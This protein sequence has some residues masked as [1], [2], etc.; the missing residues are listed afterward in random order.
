MFANCPRY[1]PIPASFNYF[2]CTTMASQDI[3]SISAALSLDPAIHHF[4]AA[5]GPPTL[6]L[7]ITSHYPDPITIYADDLSPKLMTNCGGFIITDLADGVEVQQAVRR[8]CR[9]PLPN[10][11]TVPI[12]EP[13]FHTLL[14][15]TPLTL[16]APFS[17]PRTNNRPLPRSDPEY[18]T[19]RNRVCGV[20]GL[21]SGHKYTLSLSG[22]PNI[23]WH[24][25]RWWEY[26]TKEEVLGGIKNA[27]RDG[28]AI[29]YERG[30]HEPILV[31][32]SG[33]SPIIL[34]CKP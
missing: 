31:D 2:L 22:N 5:E 34:E 11:V 19:E 15:N 12:N 3:P 23:T 27:G 17:R 33:I 7:T 28:R 13:L 6:S 9:I 18:E 30:P 21:E 10:R 25:I 29:R 20:D 24:H 8:Y 1:R 26:G 14:P 16:S 32:I 4:A